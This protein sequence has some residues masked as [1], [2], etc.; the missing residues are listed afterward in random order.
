M[1]AKGC[2]K[3]KETSSDQVVRA[4][5][6][7]MRQQTEKCAERAAHEIATRLKSDREPSVAQLAD[8]IAAELEELNP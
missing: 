4:A 7:R 3:M 6:G 5:L 1:A 8:L 2:E